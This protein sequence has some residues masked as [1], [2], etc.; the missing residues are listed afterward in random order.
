MIL[1][2]LHTRIFVAR[3]TNIN[4]ARWKLK[5]VQSTYW[6]FYQNE[7]DGA[8]LELDRSGNNNQDESY[9]LLGGRAYFIPAGVRFNTDITR[10]VGHF[11]VHFDV[12]GIPDVAMRTIFNGPICLPASERLA[13]AV[14]EIVADL[15]TQQTVDLVL[16]CRVKAVLYEG[17]ALYLQ[18]LPPEQIN[19]SLQLAI[20][21]KPVLPAINYISNNLAKSLINRELAGLCQMN[22]DYFI[23]R[24]KECIGQT[25]GDYIREQRVKLA[26][27]QLLFSAASIE[28]IAATSGF[29]SRFYLSRVFKHVTGI[30][31]AAYRK[32]SRV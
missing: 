24:F 11:F 5:N 10:E 31:P 15:T 7:T 16:E 23:R 27:Q 19:Q 13:K 25:P 1:D 2:N 20:A 29:G 30:S 9:P 21:L 8:S 12:L 6:R 14:W 18:N 28:Q 26:A 4:P 22:E 17:L 3:W 32:A